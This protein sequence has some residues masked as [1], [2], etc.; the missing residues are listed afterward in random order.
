MSETRKHF[1]ATEKMVILRRKLHVSIE[2]AGVLKQQAH[3][4]G[5]RYL[6]NRRCGHAPFLPE[7]DI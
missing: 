2:A 6:S 7:A 4:G 1:A 5:T 3:R